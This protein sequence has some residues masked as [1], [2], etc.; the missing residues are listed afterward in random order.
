MNSKGGA[1]SFDD[2]DESGLGAEDG[3]EKHDPAY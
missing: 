2:I 3:T 1:G